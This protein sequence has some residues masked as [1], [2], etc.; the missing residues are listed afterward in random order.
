MYKRQAKN[1]DYVQA[2][3]GY[4]TPS[5]APVEATAARR[6]FDSEALAADTMADFPVQL[7]G[8]LS[9]TEKGDPVLSLVI[10]V[11]ID[12]LDFA[13]RDGRQIQRCV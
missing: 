7:A 8:R 6:K 9:K 5:N 12:K 2:R 10:H 3:P 1:G 13:E 4:F 11:D